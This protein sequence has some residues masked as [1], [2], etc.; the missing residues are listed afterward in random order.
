MRVVSS[1]PVLINFQTVVGPMFSSAHVCHTVTAS[2]VM[3]GGG[4]RGAAGLCDTADRLLV[5]AFGNGAC[6]FAVP[7]SSWQR[8]Y[9]GLIASLLTSGRIETAPSNRGFNVLRNG[10]RMWCSPMRGEQR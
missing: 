7:A 2:G 5:D 6:A 1:S 8:G 10:L 9:A 4:A 3:P